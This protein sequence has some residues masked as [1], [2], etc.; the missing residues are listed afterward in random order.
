MGRVVALDLGSKRVGLAVSDPLGLT[1]QGLTTLPR[2]GRDADIDAIRRLL[3]EHEAERLIIGLPLSLNG[4]EGPAAVAARRFGESL[5]T[6]LKVPV[7]FWDERLTTVQA[8]RVLL[9]AGVRRRQRRGKVDRLA[10]VLI[11]QSWLDAHRREA[12]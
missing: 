9:L 12:T 4:T 5:A 1:A 8:E 11:L 6:E 10:A 2:R 7:D 3:V